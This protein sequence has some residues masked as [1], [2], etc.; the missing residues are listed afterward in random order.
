VNLCRG[1]RFHAAQPAIGP[2]FRLIVGG[3]SELFEAL[4][5][6]YNALPQRPRY[7]GQSAAKQQQHDEQQYEQLPNTDACQLWFATTAKKTWANRTKA[8][9]CSTSILQAGLWPSN[10]SA[11]AK[12]KESRPKCAKSPE[13]VQL[14]KK[15]A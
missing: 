3:F 13:S 5:E 6:L 10:G 7:R 11:E 9:P 1:L 4:L 15:P 14:N 12:D 2:L 8:R